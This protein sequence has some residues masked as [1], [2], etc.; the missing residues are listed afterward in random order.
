[1]SASMGSP[2]NWRE[3][4]GIR[5]V[6]ALGPSRI[7]RALVALIV[8]LVWLQVIVMFRPDL[9]RPAD[10][11]SDTSNYLAA[12]MRL[13][14]GHDLYGLSPGD[15]PVPVDNPPFFSVPLL[16][17]PPIAVLW[18]WLS[19]LPHPVVTTGWWLG[20]VVLSTLVGGLLV[21]RVPWPG[22][23]AVAASSFGLATVAWSG[24]LNAYILPGMALIWWL[25]E[26]RTAARG[27]AL[28]GGIAM[29]AAAVKLTPV[30][31]VWWLICR[32]GR[33]PMLG[34][35]STAAAVMLISVATS[36]LG[37]F[38]GYLTVARAT[39]AT[40]AT[41]LSVPG[42][43][44]SL[45]LGA[46]L[47]SLGP[48]VVAVVV[49]IAVFALRSRPRASFAV[50]VIGVVFAS[51]VV[52]VESLALLL[53]AL[54]PWVLAGGVVDRRRTPIRMSTHQRLGG[55]IAWAGA[56]AIGVV[57]GGV[58]LL[59]PQVGTSS[60]VIVN[61]SPS[62]IIVRFVHV[63]SGGTFGFEV[64]AQM[65]AGG[66]RLITGGF[67]GVVVVLDE[68]CRTISRLVPGR[69]IGTMTV[70]R[71]DAIHVDDRPG[72]ASEPGLLPFTS[73]CANEVDPSKA[74]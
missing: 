68:H 36:G 14:H 50:A 5:V 16:S 26:S 54:S 63:R 22:L 6:V 23:L 47:S 48:I 31:L 9:Q 71:A 35:A 32:R 52:R 67:E 4:P 19:I 38:L 62:A 24:N 61:D 28:A 44:E 64:P 12:G 17:P 15:R 73:R 57:V 51:P 29:L 49:M 42:I 11:G 41:P 59:A 30:F 13:A 39:A 45:G 60:V 65:A 33:S 56:G 46:R 20:G 70:S 34:A 27:W 7:G 72:T 66:W 43:L 21:L 53:A 8:L 25:S 18:R 37:P 2:I 74:Y 1:M 69:S 10:I 58:A 3:L 55:P 40:G